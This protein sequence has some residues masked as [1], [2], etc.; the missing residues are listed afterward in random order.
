MESK[1]GEGWVVDAQVEV[2][3]EVKGCEAAVVAQKGEG[4]AFADGDVDAREGS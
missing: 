2:A 3:A 1:V 4:E